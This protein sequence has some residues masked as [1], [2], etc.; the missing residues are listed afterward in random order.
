MLL[1]I[2][3]ALVSL[4]V[5]TWVRWETVSPKLVIREAATITGAV[6]GATPEVA[7]TTVKVIKAANAVTE[8]E[9]RSAGEEGPIGFR[10]G[11]VVAAKATRDAFHSVNVSADT[12]KLD[13]L[14]KLAE[15]DAYDEDATRST[16]A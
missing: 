5:Y 14:N 10:T 2:I 1:I 15:L 4:T 7:R 12:T 11:R 9:L 3:I 13:A 8:Y 6:I 16:K